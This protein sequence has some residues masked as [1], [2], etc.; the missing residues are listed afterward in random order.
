MSR[1]SNRKPDYHLATAEHKGVSL[2]PSGLLL[3]DLPSL[4]RT[5]SRV[6]NDVELNRLSQK[7]SSPSPVPSVG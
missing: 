3:Y 2:F 6:S 5:A 4:R 1:S 7:Q